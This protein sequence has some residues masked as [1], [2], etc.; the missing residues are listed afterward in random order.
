MIIFGVIWTQEDH[1]LFDNLNDCAKNTLRD[2]FPLICIGVAGMAI[3]HVSLT[4][5]YV[6]YMPHVWD[7]DPNRR[8]DNNVED[9]NY[10]IQDLNV[11]RENGEENENNIL[12]ENRQNEDNNEII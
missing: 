4:L 9:C 2:K 12:L 5:F 10:E 8:L 3:V 11:T 6:K 7:L 1:N